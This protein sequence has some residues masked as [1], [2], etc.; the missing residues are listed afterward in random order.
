MWECLP[1]AEN[2]RVLSRVCESPSPGACGSAPSPGGSLSWRY[3]CHPEPLCLLCP[4]GLLFADLA[5]FWA[6]RS[7]FARVPP[8]VQPGKDDRLAHCELSP[9][10]RWPHVGFALGSAAQELHYFPVTVQPPVRN[11]GSR[12]PVLWGLRR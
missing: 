1:C 8:Q 7:L 9:R 3:S 11:G 12:V 10:R 4:R 6:R 5:T 2:S